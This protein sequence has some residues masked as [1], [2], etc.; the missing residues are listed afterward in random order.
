MARRVETTLV[1]DLDGSVADRT[2]ALAFDGRDYEVDLS[3]ANLGML[4]SALT[5]FLEVAR[6]VSKA[7]AGKPNTHSRGQADR[8]DNRRIREWARAEGLQVPARG[9]LAGELVTAYHAAQAG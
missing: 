5:P 6:K 3:A 2:V 9:R 7:T 1:D 4:T 8:E